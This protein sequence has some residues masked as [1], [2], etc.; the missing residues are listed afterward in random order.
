MTRRLIAIRWSFFTAATL[1]VLFFQSQLLSRI[2]IWGVSPVIIVCM[3]AIAATLEPPRHAAVFALLLGAVA[4]TLFP[5]PVACFYVLVCTV[6]A[7]LSVLVARHLVV[8]GIRCALVCCFGALLLGSAVCAVV[9]LHRGAPLSAVLSLG[10]RETIVSLPFALVLI[11]PAFAHI[12][13]ITTP[14]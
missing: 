2:T 13:T 12:H 4:D 11:Y 10:L 5:A 8:P 3:A 9:M 7:G 14:R 1:L 6:V